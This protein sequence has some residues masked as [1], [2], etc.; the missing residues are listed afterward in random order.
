MKRLILPILLIN[1]AF[2]GTTT[3]KG[4]S[5]IGASPDYLELQIN[6]NTRCHESATE[7]NLSIT[8]SSKQISDFL[9][10]NI[11]LTSGDQLSVVPGMTLKKTEKEY[12][13]GDTRIICENKWSGSRK[14]TA[15]FAQVEKINNIYP[16]LIELIDTISNGN[17]S[18]R[19]EL[20]IAVGNPIPRLMPE[21]IESMET[22]ALKES[23]VKAS[24]LFEVMKETCQLENAS[25]VEISK[26][27]PVSRPYRDQTNNGS[28]IS[29][30]Q[31]Y[32]HLAYNITFSFDNLSGS[33]SLNSD[34]LQ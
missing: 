10:A 16:S 1:S 12:V 6:V 20:L 18:S 14:I 19:G 22:Q 26:S 21:T 11:D 24:E 5:N 30:E 7:S 33:C 3:V 27:S 31:Q 29:F 4:I 15:K 25:I 9:K 8:E 34:L 23:L 28:E 13:R 17:G 2:A 32:V